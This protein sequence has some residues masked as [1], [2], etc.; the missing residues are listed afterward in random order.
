M[1][2]SIPIISEFDGKGLD[3]AKKEF[4]QLE[5]VGAKANYAIKK[6]AL[7]AA[8][9]MGALTVALGSAVQGA[10]EDA[11]AQTE[12]ARS[13]AQTT[14]ATDAQIAATEDWISAQ[15]QLLGVADDDLRPALAKL[16]RATMDVTEAQKAAKLAMDISAA[17]GKNLD[18]VTSAL[19]KA[20][21]G[22][23]TALQK[24]DPSLRQVIKDGASLDEVMAML[25]VTFDGA[26]TSAANTA[27]GGMKR[28]QLSVAETK[29]SIGAA[30]LPA[31]EA[32][33]PYLLSMANWAQQNPQAFLI[34][35]GTISSIAA[36]IMAVNV[37]MA[38]NPFGAIAVGIAALVTGL[39]IAYTKFEGF[40]TLVRNVVN[41]LLG[42]WEVLANAWIRAINVII[43]GINLIKPGEDMGQL[44][45]V[46]LGRLQTPEALGPVGA[47]ISRFQ[48]GTASAQ[49][50]SNV[51]INVS[52]GDPQQVVDALRRYQQLNG[53][54]P[55]TVSA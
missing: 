53:S 12:L 29:E 19:A 20:Y 21:G 55:I 34:I 28:L 11:A 22:N 1:A 24:L 6:A 45:S 27:A 41:S 50:V 15:G 3:R 13:L 42:Y 23:L 10:M 17:T 54:I 37:A 51:T 9:A 35:A 52:G 49:S 16:G 14:G 31:V 2:I 18:S 47:D 43:R 30:L 48:G 39:A 33:L 5:G 8:A 4:S 25:G 26:A 46:S 40:R 36:A 32:V 7:P 38:L 44:S